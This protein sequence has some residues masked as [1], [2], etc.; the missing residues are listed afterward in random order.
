MKFCAADDPRTEAIEKVDERPSVASAL[1]R[2]RGY[3]AQTD[4]AIGFPKRR[5]GRLQEAAQ[6]AESA[7]QS[8][9]GGGGREALLEESPRTV[10]FVGGATRRSRQQS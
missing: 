8:R 5:R 3:R 1:R 9:K 10:A 7:S 4:V 2:R 6:D